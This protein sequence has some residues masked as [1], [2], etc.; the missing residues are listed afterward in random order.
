MDA[1]VSPGSDERPEKGLFLRIH[2]DITCWY[3]SVLKVAHIGKKKT[4]K[5]RKKTVILN[6]FKLFLI[7]LN[8]FTLF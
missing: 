7:V 5:A 8:Y 2:V 6:Y 4:K 3:K 1:G